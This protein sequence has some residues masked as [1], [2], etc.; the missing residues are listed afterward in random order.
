MKNLPGF[1]KEDL[2]QKTETVGT[3][4][5]DRFMGHKYRTLHTNAEAGLKSAMKNDGNTKKS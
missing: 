5:T 2:K 3:S 1:P 4:S